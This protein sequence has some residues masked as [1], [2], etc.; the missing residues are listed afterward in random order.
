MYTNWAG[1]KDQNL[2]SHGSRSQS[3]IRVLAGLVSCTGCIPFLFASCWWRPA[4]LH[5]HVLIHSEPKSL[6]SLDVVFLPVFLSQEAYEGSRYSGMVSTAV[7]VL[8]H[9]IPF[10]TTKGSYFY[11]SC[12]WYATQPQADTSL[13]ERQM[14]PRSLTRGQIENVTSKV[15][16]HY[17]MQDENK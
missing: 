5:L 13:S 2:S 7:T 8:T 1:S 10:R 11:K 15:I 4:T 12:W 6:P 14:S 9:E 3:K 17:K 16:N